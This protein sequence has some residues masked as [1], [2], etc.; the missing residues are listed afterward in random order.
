MEQNAEQN[1]EQNKG[2]GGDVEA[3]T[4][5]AKETAKEAVK[6]PEVPAAPRSRTLGQLKDVPL[7]DMTIEEIALVDAAA[8]DPEAEKR[9][10]AGEI[11]DLESTIE[12][13]LKQARESLARMNDDLRGLM[14]EWQAR[15]QTKHEC[16]LEIARRAKAET[17]GAAA[18]AKAE[19][20]AAQ[21]AQTKAEAEEIAKRLRGGQLV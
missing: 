15:L 1:A 19:R 10:L 5:T 7:K 8:G 11:A 16:A 21:A 12:K 2:A 17:D 14:P 3:A 4:G 9:A 18:K 13:G 6:R 20:D